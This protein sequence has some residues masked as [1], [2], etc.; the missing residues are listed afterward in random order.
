MSAKKS[1]I[2]FII[3]TKQNEDLYRRFVQCQSADDLNA[4]FEDKYDV[5]LEDCQKLI[6]AK[7]DLGVEGAMPPAYYY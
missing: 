2:D 7:S 3:D 5:S 1:F 6:Q 4:L